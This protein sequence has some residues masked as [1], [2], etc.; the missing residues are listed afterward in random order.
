MTRPKKSPLGIAPQ[1]ARV[2]ATGAPSVPDFID[3]AKR[4]GGMKAGGKAFEGSAKDEREDKKLAAKRGMSM[5]QWEKS[6][7][8]KKHDEQQ[9]MKGLKKGGGV[10]P[11]KDPPSKDLMAIKDTPMGRRMAS[12]ATKTAKMAKGGG[13]E[14]NGKTKGRMV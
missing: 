13:V 6:P 14:S 11:A 1:T 7:A 10:M 2:G 5:M 9:S 4:P 12:A 8:D 3:R